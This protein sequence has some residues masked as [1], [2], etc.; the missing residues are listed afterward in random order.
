MN[1]E[2]GELIIL[3]LLCALVI[4]CG[5]NAGSAEQAKESQEAKKLLQ[6]VWS[7]ED[8]ETVVFQ[9]KGDSVYYPDMT[10]M[11]AYFKVLDDTLYIGNSARY[12]IEKHTE[13]V[14]WFKS[15]DGEL[16]KLV[17]GNNN[18]KELFVHNDTQILTL[19]DVLKKDT[20]VMYEGE[21]YHLYIAVNPTK[22]KVTRHTVNEDG[23]DVENVYYDNI[24]HLSIF[25][26]SRQLFS[27]DFRKQ[28]YQQRVPAQFY[29][30]AVLNNMDYDSVDKQGFHMNVSLCTPGD[31][32]CYLIGH[33]VSFDGKVSTEL[34]E[35]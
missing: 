13:H 20:V 3:L 16:V 6:G 1:R 17:K 10:S 2:K 7:D 12:H 15:A 34:L 4:G 22:Y 31:A 5:Q 25:Q 33:V 24:I 8:T 30:Q 11:P 14:L 26:G 18:D 19:T 21:R 29:G 35:Y 9:M 28:Q 27:R 32:S 23:L